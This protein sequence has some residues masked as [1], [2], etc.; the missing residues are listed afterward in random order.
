MRYAHGANER[1]ANAHGAAWHGRRSGRL[2]ALAGYGIAAALTAACLAPSPTSPP[3]PPATPTAPVMLFAPTP[4]SGAPIPSDAGTPPADA[5]APTEGPTAA[6]EAPPARPTPTAIAGDTVATAGD[7]A[8]LA[9]AA[10]EAGGQPAASAPTTVA[11][12]PSARQ[13]PRVAPTDSVLAS[14]PAPPPSAV[15]AAGSADYGQAIRLV[16]DTRK[17]PTTPRLAERID[18]AVERAR[19]TGSDV[20]VV[21]WQATL[22][23]ATT[24][25]Q[26][27]FALRENRQGLRAEWEVDLATGAVRPANPLA[28]ALEGS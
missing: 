14:S 20:E 3:G 2:P 16:Q 28:E 11:L 27:T 1:S 15:V 24:V 26:V 18:S 19:S 13:L 25:Y 5:A 23:G 9:A 7:A 12:P 8:A 21:G 4:P 6:L 17:A 22:K 10:P